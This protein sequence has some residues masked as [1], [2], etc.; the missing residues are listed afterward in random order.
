MIMVLFESIEQML[1]S[2][3][4]QQ[5]VIHMDRLANISQTNMAEMT[6]AIAASFLKT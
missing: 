1:S 4:V 3:G 5:T 6:F 2:N